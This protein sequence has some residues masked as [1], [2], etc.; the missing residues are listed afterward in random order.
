VSIGSQNK[1]FLNLEGQGV[2][3]ET[4]YDPTPGSWSIT[5]TGRSA[6]VTFG[7]SATVPDAGATALLVGLGLVGIAA[8]LVA[9]RRLVR[10]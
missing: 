8:G 3:Y 6:T 7:F 10:S 9:E 4:G 5:D 1:N 2:A